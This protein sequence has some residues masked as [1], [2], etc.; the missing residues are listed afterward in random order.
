MVESAITFNIVDFNETKTN[1][2]A[3]IKSTSD[4]QTSIDKMYLSNFR[5]VKNFPAYI[6]KLVTKDDS[7]IKTDLQKNNIDINY[8]NKPYITDLAVCVR[9]STAYCCTNIRYISNNNEPEP[10]RF[11]VGDTRTMRVE[12]LNNKYFHLSSS[13]ELIELIE[14]AIEKCITALEISFKQH[15]FVINKIE[16]GHFQLYITP[17]LL[18]KIT[19]S[20]NT[21]LRQIFP[22]HFKN[23]LKS[24]DWMDVKF[25]YLE[26]NI[27]D[28]T[29][30]ISQTLSKSV[31]MFPFN[32]IKFRTNN[33]DCRSIFTMANY[34]HKNNNSE[35]EL[36]HYHLN[37]D[38][39]DKANDCIEYALGSLYD[40]IKI[41]S[42][43]IQQNIIIN[44]YFSSIDGYNVKLKLSG[45]EF[46]ELTL[47]F[48]ES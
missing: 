6:P 13:L 34:I 39:P 35:V 48:I 23:T 19:I 2:D 47:K 37:I 22:F 11:N 33:I 4:R 10:Y 27:N 46:I 14:D 8:F 45:N 30:R 5:L 40:T 31:R 44:C 15:D 26:A 36:L 1:R 3:V 38:D 17:E 29:Y 28:T 7:F 43:E 12:T 18:S 25:H 24:N 20:F 9:S 42:K 16:N 32:G 21:P 41:N